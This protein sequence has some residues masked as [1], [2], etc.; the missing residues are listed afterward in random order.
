MSAVP[1]D[2]GSSDA[3]S[4]TDD[5]PQTPSE[6]GGSRRAQSPHER[7][8]DAGFDPVAA[9]PE[10]DR[11]AARF[12]GVAAIGAALLALGLL[13]PASLVA[14]SLGAVGAATAIGGVIASYRGL[15]TAGASVQFVGV[16]AAG[17]AGAS[18]LR[19]LVATGAV[20]FAWDVGRY[21]IDLGAQLG[22]AAATTG[23]ERRHAGRSAAVIVLTG[24]VGYAVFRTVSGSQPVVGVV[25]LLIAGALL[26]LVLE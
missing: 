24:G 4:E 21:A 19:L 2:D 15:V 12:S 10:L 8:A 13:A 25:A 14:F 16:L 9:V 26:T 6:A 17:I 23:I 3:A 7:A 1:S 22:T 18:A 20:L 11:S 5:R